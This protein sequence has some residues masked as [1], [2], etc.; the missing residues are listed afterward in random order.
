MGSLQI[1]LN[2]FSCAKN[3]FVYL[4]THIQFFKKLSSL[5]LKTTQPPKTIGNFDSR[6]DFEIVA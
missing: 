5:F 2:G 6:F 3:I 4:Y 1:R